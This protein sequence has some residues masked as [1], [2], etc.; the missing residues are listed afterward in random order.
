MNTSPS[1]AYAKF[2]NICHPHCNIGDYLGF[3][4]Q[5]KS[6]KTND[7]LMIL[8]VLTDFFVLTQKKTYNISVLK[9]KTFGIQIIFIRVL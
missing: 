2:S 3:D 5:L 9:I 7:Y 6:E 1:F 4:H 8:K